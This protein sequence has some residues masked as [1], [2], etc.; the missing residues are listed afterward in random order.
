MLYIF[1]KL[2]VKSNLVQMRKNK[3]VIGE[4]W[5]VPYLADFLYLSVFAY[6]IR[7]FRGFLAYIIHFTC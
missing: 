4:K 1:L 2:C 3:K 5:G 7:Y 6:F